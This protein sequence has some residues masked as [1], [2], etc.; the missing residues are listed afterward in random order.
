[1][2]ATVHKWGEVETGSTVVMQ[3][4]TMKVLRFETESTPEMENMLFPIMEFEGHEMPTGVYSDW[5]V[6]VL[7]A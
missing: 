7:D 2:T 6:A 4:T 5:L 3:G 1:M